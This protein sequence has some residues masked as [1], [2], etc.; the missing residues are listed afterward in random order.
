MSKMM[1]DEAPYRIRWATPED[2]EQLRR[3]MR[4]SLARPE[5][6][7]PRTSYSDAIA[8]GEIL[9][10]ERSDR[11]AKQWAIEGFIEW[12]MRTDDI[13]TIRDL[14]SAG[15]EPHLGVCKALVREMIRLLSP[16][17]VQVKVR[18]DQPI[19]NSIF[20]ELPGFRQEGREFS[21]PYWRNIWVWQRRR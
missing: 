1:A 7:R 4:V 19:W 6:K 17:S 18:A 21:R 11:R 15:E 9:V 3:A 12:H 13:A 10:L 2:D 14:G 20:E 8:R 16:L 5:G